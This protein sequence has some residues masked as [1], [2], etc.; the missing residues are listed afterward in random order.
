[1]IWRLVLKSRLKKGVEA[2]WFRVEGVCLVNSCTRLACKLV[3]S[4][5]SAIETDIP[6]LGAWGSGAVLN[7]LFSLQLSIPTVEQVPVENW[8]MKQKLRVLSGAKPATYAWIYTPTDIG[9][10][11]LLMFAAEDRGFRTASPQAEGWEEA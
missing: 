4:P 3:V 8:W 9:A 7:T 5:V 2:P 11:A 6:C 10:S 1:M